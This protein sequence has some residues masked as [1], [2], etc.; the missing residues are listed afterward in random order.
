DALDSSV[1]R[2]AESAMSKSV[3]VTAACGLLLAQLGLSVLLPPMPDEL[4]YWCWAK[5]PQLSYYD[6]PPLTAYLIGVSTYVFGDNLFAIRL[7]AC[8]CM[9]GVLLLMARLTEPLWPLAFLLLT[10]LCLYGGILMTPDAPL[11]C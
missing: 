5:E 10:P 1:T 9:F 6:H 4:Y 3:Y 2:F 7:P 8:L 11:V